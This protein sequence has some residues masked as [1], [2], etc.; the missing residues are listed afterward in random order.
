[1]AII[2]ELKTFASSPNVF[3]VTQV[4]TISSVGIFAGTA[5]SYNKAIM[6][7]LRKFSSASSLAVWAEMFAYAMRKLML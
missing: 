7:S 4:V 5:F 3:L 1:M 6:P 2:H